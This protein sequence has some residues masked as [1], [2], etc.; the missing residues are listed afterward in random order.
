MLLFNNDW[1]VLRLNNSDGSPSDVKDFY[2]IYGGG[3][4][5]LS[6][7]LK[8]YENID[9]REAFADIIN[10]FIKTKKEGE[11]K[12]EWAFYQLE[13]KTGVL[14]NCG[15]DEYIMYT[16]IGPDIIPEIEVGQFGTFL[17]STKYQKV[18]KVE[19]YFNFSKINISY[20]IRQRIFDYVRFFTLFCYCD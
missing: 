20:Q 17:Y 14:E 11:Q 15:V 1:G 18:Y 7:S 3:T 19:Y 4:N 9:S 16:R 8:E 6:V 13:E 5:S 10:S 12:D 2:L